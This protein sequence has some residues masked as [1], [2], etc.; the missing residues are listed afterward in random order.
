[1]N[2][3]QFSKTAG[4][5]TAVASERNASYDC[6]MAIFLDFAQR[7]SECAIVKKNAIEIRIST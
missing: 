1:V 2:A 5:K 4:S 3:N 6:R 7:K